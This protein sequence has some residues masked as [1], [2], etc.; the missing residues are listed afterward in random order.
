MDSKKLTMPNGTPISNDSDSITTNEGY[1]MLQDVHLL[2]K[3]SH[4][5]REFQRE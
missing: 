2:D 5:V 4:F 1:T 3:L